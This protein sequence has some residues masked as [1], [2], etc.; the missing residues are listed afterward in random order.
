MEDIVLKSYNKVHTVEQNWYSLG[1][2]K[3]PGPVNPIIAGSFLVLAGFILLIDKKIISIPLPE[4][5]KFCIIPYLITRNIKESK[6]DGK[7]LFKYYMAYIPFKLKE[8]VAY[9]RFKP[10]ED[11]KEIKFFY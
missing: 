6:K 9:E 11:M 5:I 4:V 2:I 8:K 10:V 7:N 1:S 3:L